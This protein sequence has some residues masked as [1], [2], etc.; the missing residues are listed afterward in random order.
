MAVFDVQFG[1]GCNAKCVSVLT[2]MLVHFEAQCYT[3]L[4]RT[5]RKM[6]AAARDNFIVVPGVTRVTIFCLESPQ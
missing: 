2:L 6:T 4:L 5:S 1:F 3:W